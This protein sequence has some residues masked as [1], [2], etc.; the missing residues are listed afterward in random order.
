M[1]VIVWLDCKYTRNYYGQE[2]DLTNR[3]TRFPH[4]HVNMDR[5]CTAETRAAL[6]LRLIM[7][8]FW[9]VVMAPG[10]PI[11]PRHFCLLGVSCLCIREYGR[12]WSQADFS[13]V[14]GTWLTLVLMC[15]AECHTAHAAV[16]SLALQEWLTCQRFIKERVSF[17][18]WKCEHQENLTVSQENHQALMVMESCQSRG[19]WFYM[20]NPEQ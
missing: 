11:A 20:I 16:V 2:S 15:T 8:L 7:V 9:F 14:I 18:L 19:G 13:P 3:K 5:S 12:H 4:K 1:K 17:K 6:A 10:I